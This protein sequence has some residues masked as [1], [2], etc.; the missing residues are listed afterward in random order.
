MI[1]TFVEVKLNNEENFLKIRETLSR[2]GIASNKDK[3][4]YQSCHILHKQGKYYITHFKEMFLLDGKPSNFSSED[5]D[6]RDAIAQLLEDWGLVK[7]I[8]KIEKKDFA[9]QKIKILPFSEKGDWS[10]ITKYSIGK[11]K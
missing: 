1:E 4:L 7:I 8:T 10:L 5:R 2:I 6:R 3:K 11:K 9:S